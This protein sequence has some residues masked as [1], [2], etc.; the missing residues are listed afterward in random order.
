MQVIQAGFEHLEMLAQLFDEYRLFYGQDSDLIGA[1]AFLRDRLILR[2]S[3][4]FLALADSVQGPMAAGFTQLYPSFSSVSM[5][6]LWILNDLYV[7]PT[8]RR[9]GVAQALMK[10]ARDY[11]LNTGAV[12]IQ[13]STE[14]GNTAAQ[15]LY[16]A[17]G[18]QPAASPEDSEHAFCHYSLAL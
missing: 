13:L 11:A 1:Q 14:V 2:D 4:I 17:L 18:Y 15:S 3:I 12:R 7:N 8:F 5:G 10:H 9:Q 16:E 6:S